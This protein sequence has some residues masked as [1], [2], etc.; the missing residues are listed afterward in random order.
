MAVCIAATEIMRHRSSPRGVPRCWTPVAGMITESYSFPADKMGTT[1]C[2]LVTFG[3]G[4]ERSQGV[5]YSETL[6]ALGKL[7]ADVGSFR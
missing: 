2:I 3:L 6:D 4:A 7:K 1:N 5:Y